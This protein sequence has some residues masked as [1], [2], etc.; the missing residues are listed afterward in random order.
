M[1][2]PAAGRCLCRGGPRSAVPAAG[3]PVVLRA[4]GVLV[5]LPA[6]CPGGGALLED[7]C[8]AAAL[9]P[10]PGYSCTAPGVR[11]GLAA[12][13]GRGGRRGDREGGRW[14]VRGP[15]SG[16]GAGHPLYDCARVG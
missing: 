10:L 14:R 8:A 9:R 3:V 11:A 1:A 6:S 16:G 15:A 7:L 13:R 5:W 4:A 12:G 2:V